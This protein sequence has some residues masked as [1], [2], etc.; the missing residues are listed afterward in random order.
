QSVA[1]WARPAHWPARDVPTHAHGG[2]HRRPQPAPARSD[3]P[4]TA[5]AGSPPPWPDPARRRPVHCAIPRAGADPATADGRPGG[6]PPDPA[7]RPPPGTGPP[8][9]D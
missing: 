8:P 6:F 2:W 1:T 4:P 3:R 9:S 5:D 7:A